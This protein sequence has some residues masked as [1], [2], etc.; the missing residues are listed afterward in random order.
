[1]FYIKCK[2]EQ[3]PHWVL[4]TKVNKLIKTAI[5]KKGTPIGQSSGSL[6]LITLNYKFTDHETNTIIINYEVNIKVSERAD[7][8]NRDVSGH[9]QLRKKER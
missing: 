6:P 9:M 7:I 8:H 3:E 2:C 5:P 1:M 4:T